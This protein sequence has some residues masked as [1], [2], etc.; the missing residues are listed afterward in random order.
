MA[1]YLFNT[2]FEARPELA[3]KLEIHSKMHPIV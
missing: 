3:S 1:A 2:N